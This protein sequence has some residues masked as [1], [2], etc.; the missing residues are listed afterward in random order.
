[1]VI[2]AAPVHYTVSL[3]GAGTLGGT[4]FTATTVTLEFDS[5]TRQIIDLGDGT[6]VTPNGIPGTYNIAGF[7][8][9]IITS[10]LHLFVD[11]TSCPD[12]VAGINPDPD[13]LSFGNP[14]YA[15]YDLTTSIGP[16]NSTCANYLNRSGLATNN[17]QLVLSSV[18]DINFTATV[19]F[20]CRLN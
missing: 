16:V 8:S 6:F 13:F 15:T 5:D 20:R 3:L 7:S 10:S 9:G 18:R 14:A 2:N 19:G 1:V 11:Q 17:G 4:A 12:A